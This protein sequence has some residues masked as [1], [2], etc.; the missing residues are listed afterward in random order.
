MRARRQDAKGDR[1]WTRIDAKEK[2]TAD[3]S[4][5]ASLWRDRRRF[6]QKKQ[7]TEDHKENEGWILSAARL[8]DA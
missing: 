6:T 7:F 8:C 4:A 5:A 1:E 2:P 3:E